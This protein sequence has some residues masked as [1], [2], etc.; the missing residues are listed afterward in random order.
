V[1]SATWN[2]I[3]LEL[4]WTN[5]KVR[6]PW[7][8]HTDWPVGMLKSRKLPR[9]AVRREEKKVVDAVQFQSEKGNA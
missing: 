9:G 1:E 6:T 3:E 8:F 5:D 2:G 7:T 4:R